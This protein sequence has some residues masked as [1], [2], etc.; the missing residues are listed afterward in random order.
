DA[1]AVCRS[2]HDSREGHVARRDHRRVRA[3]A[4]GAGDDRAHAALVRDLWRG[5][6]DL[7][8]AVFSAHA[9]RGAARITARTSVGR[10]SGPSNPSGTVLAPRVRMAW[11]SAAEAP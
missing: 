5:G 9:T 4:R 7:L 3:H 10:T 11:R 2:L 8:R 6:G 1:A